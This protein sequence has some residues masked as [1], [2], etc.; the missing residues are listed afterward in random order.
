MCEKVLEPIQQQ[1]G[2][3]SIRSAYRSREVNAKGAEEK[4]NCATNES[5]YAKHIWDVRDADGSMGATACIIVTSFIPYYEK[6][7]DWTALAWWICDRIPDY[8]DLEFFSKYAAFN[9]SWHEN[10]NYPKSIYSHIKDPHTNKKGY[11]AKAG[12]S[13]FTGDHAEFYQKFVQGLII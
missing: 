7:G 1:L 5:N 10:P 12:M 8:A 4:Y 9:I 13:N 6:T 11:L 3:I 2:R